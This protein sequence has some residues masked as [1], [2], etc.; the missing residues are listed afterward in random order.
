M[1]ERTRRQVRLAYHGSASSLPDLLKDL[2][3]GQGFL[4][5]AVAEL[6][7]ITDL[8]LRGTK[9]TAAVIGRSMA[10]MVTTERHL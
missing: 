2:D 7:R 1:A 10:V 3:Q 5:E 6:R 4:P 8:A 9:Q